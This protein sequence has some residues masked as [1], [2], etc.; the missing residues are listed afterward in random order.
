MFP[1]N[2]HILLASRLH[3][4]KPRAADKLAVVFT[5]IIRNLFTLV[6]RSLNFGMRNPMVL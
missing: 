2:P 4:S 1:V 3:E 5:F 6:K